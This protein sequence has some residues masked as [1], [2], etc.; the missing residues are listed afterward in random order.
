[1]RK[2]TSFFYRNIAK[3]ILFLCDPEDVHDGMIKF[4]ESI[5]E[6]KIAKILISKIFSYQNPKLENTIH[7]I[8]FKNPVGLAAGFDKNARLTQI[9]PSIGFGFEEIGSI[10]LK[11]CPGNPKPRLYRL[12]KSQGIIVNYGLA[13][14]GAEKVLGNLLLKRLD[15]PIGISVAKTNLREIT[16]KEAGIA[17]YKGCFEKVI[18]SKIGDYIT[19][20]ISCPNAYGGETFTDPL[21]LKDLLSELGAFLAFK[22]VFIK[23][24]ADISRENLEKLLSICLN[25]SVRGIILTNLAKDRTSASIDQDE[26][27]KAIP[28][29]G[30]SG[31]PTFAKSNDLIG[32]AYKN[33]GKDFIIVGCGG[34]FSAEDAYK[35]IKLGASLV[36]LI[37]GLIFRGPQLV[38]EINRDLVSLLLRDG[39]NNIKDAIGVEAR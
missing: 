23:M 27:K 22:P 24:P 1:M 38:G 11:P 33:F 20:N 13:N 31:K 12:P 5:G 14:W 16:T 15:F 17:D 9:L 36:Q 28:H 35:K 4:G 37:T 34:I 29:G 25:Y 21:L 19:I 32:F 7:G 6:S 3:P 18:K 30:I 2:I 39:F 10:T 26:I 8:N